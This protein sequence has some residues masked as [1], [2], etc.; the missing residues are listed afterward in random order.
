MNTERQKP[1]HENEAESSVV[2]FDDGAK[3]AA[4]PVVPLDSASL[5]EAR[6]RRRRNGKWPLGLILGL[7]LVTLG[8]ALAGALYREERPPE[9][10]A[11][12][13]AAPVQENTPSTAHLDIA[14]AAAGAMSQA[15]AAPRISLERRF[16]SFRYATRR[17]DR[18]E[19]E[20]VEQ[21]LKRAERVR[22]EA[23]ER[24]GRRRGREGDG[25]P[26]PRLI[27]VYTLKSRH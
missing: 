4:R 17:V 6:R 18:Y 10:R 8:A 3:R 9:T 25:P 14:Q 2:R 23:E 20:D 19:D 13:V 5:E 26:K 16:S 15:E 22:K 27:G 24:A 12:T 21:L 7:G 11:A 1:P